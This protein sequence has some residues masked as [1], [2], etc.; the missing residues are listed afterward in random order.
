MNQ[1]NCRLSKIKYPF[2]IHRSSKSIY[3][4]KTYKASELRNFLLY[5]GI[6]AFK[7]ILPDEYFDHFLT[8]IIAIRLLTEQKI[9]ETS[10]VHAFSLISFFCMRY[11][12]LY[13]KEN[14]TYKIHVQ[15]HLPLQ[16]L[17]F[18]PLQNTSGF[19]FEGFFII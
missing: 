2:E 11:Q 1:I 9:R 5:I 3:D 15:T 7:D 10:I 18:G 4:Y 14:M 8:Y 16:V 13:G 17:N 12:K 6:M 19:C